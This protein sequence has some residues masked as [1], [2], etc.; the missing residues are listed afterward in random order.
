MSPTPAVRPPY[1]VL[2]V[3]CGPTGTSVLRGLVSRL[4]AVGTRLEYEVADPAVMGPGLAFSTPYDLHLLNVRADRMSLHPQDKGEFAHWRQRSAAAHGIPSAGDD[5]P[6][7][8]LFGAYARWVLDDVL[9]TARR[10]GP[11]V[12]VT[13]ERAVAVRRDGDGRWRCRFASGRV[14]T[15]D[16]V[17]LA[18]G[19]L[20]SARYAPEE[21]GSRFLRDP[22]GGLEVP[23]D[24][25]VGVIGTRLTGVDV[26]LALLERGHAGPVLLASRSGLL[27]SVKGR[28]VAYELAHLPG[29]VADQRRH[30]RDGGVGLETVA[31]VIGREVQEAEGARRI[32]WSEVLHP[33]PSSPVTLR[34]G[35]AVAE[36]AGVL[37]RQSVLAAVV[38]WVPAL[39]RLLDELG[40][41]RLMSTYVGVWAANIASFPAVSA[42]R[43]LGMMD[44]GRLA[45]RPGLIGV[46]PSGSGY[47]M[48]FAD[49]SPVSVDVVVNA[50]GPGYGR[51]SLLAAPLTRDLLSSRTAVAHR[52][53]GVAVDERTFE[54]RGADGSVAPGLHVVGDLTRGVW[55]ATNAVEN[56]VSQA[57]QLA[58]VVAGAVER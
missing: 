44:D 30:G 7:R 6:P 39:W 31:A 53:G 40:K 10:A 2:Q 14:A 33:P 23:A 22:W 38:P 43:L 56:S 27:P 50:T 16:R 15:Y 37:G 32:R 36:S 45:V 17:V 29:F 18:L 47:E 55:L 48:R 26:A 46:R 9:R 49:A 21:G 20:P 35:L 52:F 11:G 19:H 51:D 8:R 34:A 3:G 58:D 57:A 41:Q 13:H 5:Y 25:R 24:A 12:R 28:T 54:V 42:R 1:R 4:D